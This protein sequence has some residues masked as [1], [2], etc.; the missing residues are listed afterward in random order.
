MVVAA[1]AGAGKVSVPFNVGR[2]PHANCRAL[3]PTRRHEKIRL[4]PVTV[5]VGRRRISVFGIDRTI[6][7]FFTGNLII[8]HM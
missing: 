1:T 4:F 8:I 3:R 6:Y 2:R 7:V 5:T